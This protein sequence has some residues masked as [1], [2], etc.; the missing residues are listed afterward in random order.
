MHP[1]NGMTISQRIVNISEVVTA[2]TW[3]DTRQLQCVL[4]TCVAKTPFLGGK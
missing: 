1:F 2:L 3:F 4:R